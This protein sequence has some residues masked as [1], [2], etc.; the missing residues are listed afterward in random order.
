MSHT[1]ERYRSEEIAPG[2]WAISQGLDKI[3]FLTVF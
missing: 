2:V 1:D 3:V